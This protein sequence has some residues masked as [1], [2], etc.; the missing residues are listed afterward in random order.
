MSESDAFTTSLTGAFGASSIFIATPSRLFTDNVC[1][2]TLSIVARTRTTCGACAAANDA[3][4]SAATAAGPS[5]LR[6]ILRH[7]RPPK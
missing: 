4:N 3:A 7:D 1:P 2:L 6:V 5:I